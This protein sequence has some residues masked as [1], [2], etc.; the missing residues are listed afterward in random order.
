[1]VNEI[2]RVMRIIKQE[3][4]EES[5][6]CLICHKRFDIR[7]V[8]RHNKNTN[9]GESTQFCDRIVKFSS[10]KIIYGICQNKFFNEGKEQ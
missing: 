4:I 10:M 2:N 6:V 8:L 9:E 3:A 7:K 1:M 5:A